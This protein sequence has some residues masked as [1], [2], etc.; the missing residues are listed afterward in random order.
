MQDVGLTGIRS[1]EIL[2]II[3]GYKGR[4]YGLSTED[5]LG[6]Y[7]SIVVNMI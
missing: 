1:E 7:F 4:G 6:L 3:D 2:D 5:E